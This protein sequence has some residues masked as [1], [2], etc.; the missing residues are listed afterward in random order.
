MKRRLRI[1]IEVHDSNPEVL[2]S[3]SCKYFTKIDSPVASQ[4]LWHYCALFQVPLGVALQGG[5]EQ[6]VEFERADPCR[7]KEAGTL[8]A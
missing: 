1:E 3:R 5:N 6:L 8:E 7:R 4:R 2:C